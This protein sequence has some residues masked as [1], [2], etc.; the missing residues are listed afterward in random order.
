MVLQNISFPV[1]LRYSATINHM[2]Y[3]TT[4]FAAGDSIEE[5]SPG[6]FILFHSDFVISKL[7]RCGSA[8]RYQGADSIYAHY[9]HCALIVNKDLV[10]ESKP[11]NGVRLAP[12]TKYAGRPY[13]VVHANPVGADDDPSAA[14]IMRHNAMDFALS[15]VGG[16]YG[17]LTIFCVSLNLLTGGSFTFGFDSQNTCSGLV[18]RSLERMGYNFGHLNPAGVM[19]ADLAHYFKVQDRLASEDGKRWFLRRTWRQNR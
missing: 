4:F 19:P 1:D 6:D 2:S 8:R 3:T 11:R 7:I 10:I 17:F 13:V 12:L 5:P 15:H 14:A 18:A 16:P 9:N